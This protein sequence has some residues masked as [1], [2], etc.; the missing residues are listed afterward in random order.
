M[1]LSAK[2][3]AVALALAAGRTAAEA[4]GEHGCGERTV[5]RWLA[6]VPE[7]RQRIEATRTALFNQAVGKLAD[8]CG[9]AATTL[10]ELLDSEA[11]GVRLRAA[12]AILSTA[13]QLREAT[14]L[15][16]KVD[17]LERRLAEVGREHNGASQ[18]GAEGGTN[19]RGDGHQEE[20]AAAGGTDPAGPEPDPGNGRDGAGPLAGE[21]PPLFR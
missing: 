17:D 16:A 7:F 3:Q 4:A 18:A 14:G 2:Q 5:R 21:T 11:E 9:K 1:P 19:A 12:Q 13:P 6:E 20:G 15:A 10:G 8:L